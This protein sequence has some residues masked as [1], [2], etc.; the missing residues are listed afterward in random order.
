MTCPTWWA[1]MTD[2]RMRIVPDAHA[3]PSRLQDVPR[4]ETHWGQRVQA[5]N[6]RHGKRHLTPRFKVSKSF[7]TTKNMCSKDVQ[8]QSKEGRV[9]QGAVLIWLQSSA[10][11]DL[12]T[13][14]MKCK[15][16]QNVANGCKWLDR[17]FPLDG[18]GMF[19]VSCQ[20]YKPYGFRAMHFVLR[21]LAFLL[22]YGPGLVGTKLPILMFG[23]YLTV[24]SRLYNPHGRSHVHFKWIVVHLTTHDRI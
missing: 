12:R 9:V 4:P 18:L 19:G 6:Y 11:L 21:F 13:S 15:Y 14:T 16:I 17:H 20:V 3:D 8:M 7:D 1:V 2:L 23:F 5:K 24:G 22:A 10:A